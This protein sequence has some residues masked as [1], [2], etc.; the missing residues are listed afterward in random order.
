MTKFIIYVS[1]IKEIIDRSIIFSFGPF[2]YRLG[3]LVLIQVRGV[4]LPYGLRKKY[5]QEFRI[6][7]YLINYQKNSMLYNI[8]T[9]KK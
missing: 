2:V 5:P 3:R 9:F 8:N 7:F 6:F 4:R 1:I